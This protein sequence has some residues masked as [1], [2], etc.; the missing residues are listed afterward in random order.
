MLDRQTP[1]LEIARRILLPESMRLIEEADISVSA[2]Q[3][4]DR[5]AFNDP[6]SLCEV[7]RD[8]VEFL[9]QKIQE[10]ADL[11]DEILNSISAKRAREH[12]MCDM[13]IMQIMGPPVGY[14]SAWK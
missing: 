7:E 4:L 13:E 11:E 2:K 1:L 14:G 12:G 6:T 5:W 3:V 8:G 9:L 10:E